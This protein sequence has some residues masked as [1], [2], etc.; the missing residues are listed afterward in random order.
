MVEVTEFDGP[1]DSRRAYGSS[2]V[3]VPEEGSASLAGLQTE[4]HIDDSRVL[5]LGTR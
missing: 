2:P 3:F 1:F 4:G 5:R